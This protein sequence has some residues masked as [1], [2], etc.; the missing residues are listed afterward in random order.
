MTIRPVKPPPAADISQVMFSVDISDITLLRD[1][2]RS[3]QAFEGT[4]VKLDPTGEQFILDPSRT[5]RPDVQALM[6]RLLQFG[7]LH[8]QIRKNIKTNLDKRTTGSTQRQFYT[9][10]LQELLLFSTL[11]SHLDS[12][13]PTGSQT[14]KQIEDEELLPSLVQSH[15]ASHLHSAEPIQGSLS[16][17]VFTNIPPSHVYPRQSLILPSSIDEPANTPTQA[18]P[19]D[20]F[21]ADL[22]H[23]LNSTINT[24]ASESAVFLTSLTLRRL[25]VYMSEPTDK[26]ILLWN[27]LRKTRGMRGGQLLSKINSEAQYGSPLMKKIYTNLLHETSAPLYQFISRWIQSGELSDP[28]REFF[29]DEH[30]VGPTCQNGNERWKDRFVLRREMVPSFITEETALNILLIG[31][32]L[33]FLR[34]ECNQLAPFINHL[35]FLTDETLSFEQRFAKMADCVN[36]HLRLFI[37]QRSSFTRDVTAMKD[38]VLLARGDF[39]LFMMDRLWGSIARQAMTAASSAGSV[40]MSHAQTQ[41]QIMSLF[42][43]SMHRDTDD[44]AKPEQLD[45]RLIENTQT[46]LVQDRQHVHIPRVFV[47]SYNVVGPSRTIITQQMV[48]MHEQAFDFLWSVKRAN[49]NLSTLRKKLTMIEHMI[50]GPQHHESR[51]GLVKYCNTIRARMMGFINDLENY[52]DF[53]VLETSWKHF[54]EDLKKTTSLDDIT[55]AFSTYITTI[56]EKIKMGSVNERTETPLYR[57][58][59]SILTIVFRFDDVINTIFM[60]LYAELNKKRELVKAA[61][62]NQSKQEWGMDSDRDELS[63]PSQPFA[64]G[65]TNTLEGINREFE[66]ALR[67]LQNIANGLI[68]TRDQIVSVIPTFL[69]DN[70]KGSTG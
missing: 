35:R 53:E 19:A 43:P 67:N 1:C 46:G 16:S 23:T 40:E 65:I 4:Y 36:R 63:R 54:S 47:L 20:P 68:E 13:I 33:V 22:S 24:S 55:D 8:H 7:T 44:F 38:F 28:H 6:H 10:I 52:F 66:A 61:E 69:R 64:P 57:Q 39:T 21:P 14:I 18:G 29:V 59:V 37:I 51:K 34:E 70:C 41:N 26:I 31:K 49:Y 27:I 12:Q 60:G 32:S 45:V 30:E 25:I 58:I 17:Q 48:R 50:S 62:D 2:I 15:S 3:F 56:L 9:A 11:I 5:F 42:N